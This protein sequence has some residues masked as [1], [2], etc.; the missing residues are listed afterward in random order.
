MPKPS[1]LVLVVPEQKVFEAGE[2]EGVTTD[3]ALISNLIKNAGM[4]A[5]Y[6]PHGELEG[7]STQ[8]QL[9]PY[10]VVRRNKEIFAYVRL[11]GGGESRLSGKLSIGVGGHMN[12]ITIFEKES[13]RVHGA[14][15]QTTIHENVKRELEEE[16]EYSF[17][18]EDCQLQTIGLI[19]D[20]KEEVGKEHIGLLMLLQIPPNADV[21]VREKDALEGR[22]MTKNEL[23]NYD[24]PVE[25]WTQF[26]FDVI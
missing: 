3:Q 10:V 11:D 21:E 20:S 1:E 8:K 5:A 16:L 9:I 19:N 25:S 12:E 7:D 2:F 6:K 15:I 17:D 26:A 4:F 13:G 23:M 14:R 18:L 22:W 24:G